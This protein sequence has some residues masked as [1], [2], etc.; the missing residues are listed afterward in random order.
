MKVALAK[1]MHEIDDAA[2]NDLGLPELALMES[3]GHRVAQATKN[4]F[5]EINKKSICIL[6]GSGNNGGDALVAARYLSNLGARIKIFLI[7]FL[8]RF[9]YSIGGVR[10]PPSP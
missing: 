8:L 7:S 2:I 3:A 9:S 4:F 5:G 6:A 10:P 1:Q